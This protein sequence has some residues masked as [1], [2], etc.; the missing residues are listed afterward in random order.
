MRNQKTTL[1]DLINQAYDHKA[2]HGANLRGSL[3]GVT[4][5]LAAE[6][7]ARGRHNIWENVV[8]CA[9]WKYAIWRRITGD[10]TVAFPVKGSNWFERPHLLTAAVW[11][12]DIAL[13]DDA[14]RTLRALVESLSPRDLGRSRGASKFD[15]AGMLI[16][17]AAHDV[18]HAG[19]I[20]LLKKLLPS[21]A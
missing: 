17:I 14:H 6:R 2:W 15:V 5:P 20:Q 13:L 11:R 9:Y 16:G 12:A 19:Q 4:A 3:R 7:P 1:L 18:Y 10:T 21:R 8:H